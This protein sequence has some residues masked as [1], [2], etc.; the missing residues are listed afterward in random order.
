ME[1]RGHYV[2][3]NLTISQHT[4]VPKSFEIL[5]KKIKPK[6][7]L[8][9]GTSFGGLTLL[10][11]DLLD[12]NG[13]TETKL[14]TYDVYDP[15]YLRE[16]VSKGS[17]IDIRVKNVF[18][19]QYNELIDKDEISEIIQSNGVTLVLCDGGSKK[20]EFRILSDYLKPGDVIMA[21]DYAPNETYF[22]EHI[23]NKIWN[24]LEIQDT[25]INESCVKNNLV[26]FMEE[27]FTQVVW[28]CKI[29]Q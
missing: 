14:I 25:D 9:I 27:D 10:I 19:H 18:N 20:N 6:Q 15:V 23:N 26:P 11:R 12:K 22:Q 13:L 3:K 29:K 4:S 8:E 21:H 1:V 24:W 28:V 16:N 2:Y 7:V 5:I 17:N